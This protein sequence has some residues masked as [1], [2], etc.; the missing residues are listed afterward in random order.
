VADDLAADI[1][2]AA[3]EACLAR[4]DLDHAN[5]LAAIDH[6]KHGRE[7]ASA[8]RLAGA[9]AWYWFHRGR[10]REGRRGLAEL[11]APATGAG[12]AS[13]ARALFADGLLAWTPGDHAGARE[14]LEDSVRCWRETSDAAGLGH[15]LQFLAVELLGSDE[16]HEATRLVREGVAAFRTQGDPF[17]LATSPASAGIVALSRNDLPEARALFEESVAVSG[18]IP[19]PW[20][21]ALA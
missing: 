3:R 16:V 15:A 8:Q 13:R 12:A 7:P 17:G 1:N 18:R 6:A 5:F 2:T 4:L 9:L 14:R 19:D 21:L 20:A 10:W 11:V